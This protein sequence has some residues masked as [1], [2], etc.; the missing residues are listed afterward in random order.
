VRKKGEE[1]GGKLCHGG[2]KERKGFC[3]LKK[4]GAT[5]RKLPNLPL[6][7]GWKRKE[8]TPCFSVLQGGNPALRKKAVRARRRKGREK[9]GKE[10]LRLIKS[11]NQMDY[12]DR[13]KKKTFI[14][15]GKRGAKKERF[16]KEISS[17]GGH[18]IKR[19]MWNSRKGGGKREYTSSSLKG[20]ATGGRKRK[21]AFRR[22]KEGV[23][24][25]EKR[26]C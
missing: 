21:K 15:L 5:E 8:T 19:G 18:P 4:D 3:K 12:V 26:P 11:S 17:W 9:R 16:T 20:I 25:G 23:L 10:R 2:G 22:K 6:I 7:K 13:V 14:C 1:K 24:A